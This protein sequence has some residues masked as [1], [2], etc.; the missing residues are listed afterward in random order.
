MT[1]TG[2][3]GDGLLGPIVPVDPS[4]KPPKE[5]SRFNVELTP[6]RIKR[7]ELVHLSR[8]LA[9]FLRAGVPV[10]A[11]LAIIEGD[12]DSSAVRKVVSQIADD[13]RNGATLTEAFDQ[14]PRDFPLYY[15]R[16]LASAELTGRLDQVL[17]SLG[18]YVEQDLEARRKITSAL[19][20][21]AVVMAMAVIT[22]LILSVAVLPQFE[23]FFQ[24][25]SIELPLTTRILL[26]ITQ[27]ITRW[28]LLLMVLTIVVGVISWVLIRRGVGK[29]FFD[30]VRLRLPVLGPLYNLVLTERFCRLMASLA[31]AGVPLT[32]AMRV[33]S[34][35][36]NNVVFRD[37]LLEAQQGMVEGGGLSGPLAATGVFPST[38]VQMI[39]VGEATGTLEDQMEVAATFYE[40]ELDHKIKK[41]TTL[42][43]P[44]VVLVVGLVVG[45]V[46]VAL[47]SAMYGIFQQGSAQ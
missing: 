6:K 20:Y 23:K 28:G 14:H 32:T 13:L 22:V 31:N 24:S 16:I 45:F 4:A 34:E 2:S 8:Q 3:R 15:R 7:E 29:P 26:A 33:T 25:L 5:R 12:G 36:M 30:R 47:V 9:A 37:A 41:V 27:F 10:L 21:P 1:T 40:R 17:D 39:R 46:A 38:V 11:A 43:E 35:T 42:I 18:D 19:T 44:A